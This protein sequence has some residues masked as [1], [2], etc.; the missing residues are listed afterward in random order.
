MKKNMKKIGRIAIISLF[1]VVLLDLIFKPNQESVEAEEI[2]K[3]VDPGSGTLKQ[4]VENAEPGTILKL[5]AGSY[6]GLASDSDKT[7][8]IKE[9]ITIEG[10]DGYPSKTIINVPIVVE[11]SEKVIISNFTTS[12]QVVEPNFVF[13]KTVGKVDLDINNVYIYGILRGDSNGRFPRTEA[14]ALNVTEGLLNASES[15]RS[16]INITNSSL[17]KPGTHYGIRV[18][19]SN[20]TLNLNKTTVDSRISV[21]F[22]N[23]ENNIFNLENNSSITAPSSSYQDNETIVIK[24]Q[25]NLEINIDNSTITG[26]PP[27]GNGPTKMFSFSD[28]GEK[29]TNVK[30]NVKNNSKLID[31]DKKNNL[32]NSSIIFNYRKDNSESDNN[33]ITIDNTSKVYILILEEKNIPEE[34]MEVPISREYS[35]LDNSA[36]VSIFDSKGNREI[37]IYDNETPIAELENINQKEGYV[38]KGWFKTFENNEYSN[39]YGKDGNYP[40]AKSGEN[41]DL[42]PKF[43][44]K[45][46]ITIGEE[47]FAI[48]E[49]QTINESSNSET[50]KEALNNIKIKDGQDFRGF[51]I[52]NSNGSLV[53]DVS[54][55]EELLNLKMTEDCKIEAT[56]QVKVTVNGQD[57]WI[58][59]GETLNDI[60]DR[61]VYEEAKNLNS[62]GRE[63]SRFV[64][65][66]GKTVTEEE[67][68]PS[69]VK[70]TSKYFQKVTIDGKDYN[71]EEGLILNSSEEIKNALTSI[72]KEIEGRTFAK[73][74][75]AESREEIKVNEY[76]VNKDITVKAIYTITV[77][78]KGKENPN[79]KFTIEADN[80][81]RSYGNDDEIIAA[82][83]DVEASTPKGLH[84]DGYVVST[85]KDSSNTK[86]DTEDDT[87]ENLQK[88]ILD[89]KLSN[90]TT[91]YA[92]YVVKITIDNGTSSDTFEIESGQTLND[93]LNDV[94]YKERYQAVKLNG[95]EEN[96][97]YKF[98][99]S[100]NNEI[101]ETDEITKSMTLTPKYLVFVTIEDERDKVKGKF[102]LEEGDS[103]D[104]LIGEDAQN[105]LAT[106]RSDIDS[107]EG[108]P[109]EDYHFDKLVLADNSEIP[110]KITEDITIKA[111]YHYDVII[112]EDYDNPTYDDVIEVHEGVKGFKVYKGENLLSKEDE[113]R[114]A[115]DKLKE[116]VNK[117]D[118]RKFYSYLEVNTN[119]EFTEAQFDELLNHV[120]KTHIYISAKVAYKV[121]INDVEDYVVEGKSLKDSE[122]GLLVAEL[123]KLKSQPDKEVNKIIINGREYSANEVD[124]N[125]II[126]EYTEIT[127]TYN[128]KVS[129]N[130]HEF[131]LPENGKLEDL[132]DKTEEIDNAL[133]ELKEQIKNNNHNFKEFID[134]DGNSFTKETVVRKNTTVIATY[135]IKVTIESAAGSKEFEI[136]AGQ[137]LE[138]VKQ[139]NETAFAEVQ[140][141]ENRK[142][143]HFIVD[144]S[145]KTI[146]NADDK[147]YKFTENTTLTSIYAVTVTINDKGYDIK[148]GSTLGTPEI[149]E[150]LKDFESEEK[151]L[152]G[153][154]YGEDN[155]AITIND[156]VNDNITIKPVYS[157]KLTIKY[158]EEVLGEFE[159]DENT[160]INDSNELKQAIKDALDALKTK[161]TTAGYNFKKFVANDEEFTENTK[162]TKN[163]IVN[164]NYN[165]MVTI[166]NGSLTKEFEL[167]SNQTLNDIPENK[168]TD[169]QEVITKNNRK[170]ADK[171]YDESKN[172]ITEKTSLVKNITL[173]PI[174]N[175]TVTIDGKGYDIE[176]GTTLG[177][178]EIVEALKVFE[179]TEKKLNGYVYGESKTPIKIT[180]TVNDNITISPV[181]VVI[182]TIKDGEVV[183]GE[184]EL[185]ENTS[186][187]ENPAKKQEIENALNTLKNQVISNG[188]NF[189]GYI[190][191]NGNTFTL[192]TKITKNIVVGAI[193]NIKVTIEGA[194]GSKEFEIEAGQTLED[195]KN[196]NQDDFAEVQ[197]KDNRKFLYFI[198][199]DSNNTKLNADDKTYK[200]AKNTS[201]T[202]V[203][204]VTVT[205][206][207]KGYDIK[208]GG[209][210]SSYPQVI[211]ALKKLEKT[212]QRLVEYLDGN[213]NIIATVEE[214]NNKTDKGINDNLTIKPKYVIDVEIVGDTTY[215]ETV[216]VGT[217]LSEIKYPKPE[218]FAGYVDYNTNAPVEETTALTKHTKL[219]VIYKVKVSINEN[220]YYLNSFQ[221]FGEL[222]GAEED[223]EAL[224]EVP[225][226]KSSFNKFIYI[227]ANNEEI[228]L[229]KDTII[230][231]DI[232][233]LPKFNVEITVVYKNSNDELE[234]II[235]FELEDGKAIGSLPKEELDKLNEKLNE[236]TSQLEE[237]GKLNYK[238]S[239]FITNEGQDIDIKATSFTLNTTIEAVFE[240]K[241]ESNPV[242]PEK[243]EDNTGSESYPEKEPAPNT[244]VFTTSSNNDETTKT[245]ITLLTLIGSILLSIKKIFLRRKA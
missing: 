69:N 10:V 196:T 236:K 7:I 193:H 146:L 132:T 210:L 24:E 85:D 116:S 29:S 161:V 47:E 242:T 33:V 190:D 93:I 90:D 124:E 68:I 215:K 104:N 233:V 235:K 228:T 95:R 176:E 180:D 195:V 181:Y 49:G 13:I 72:S 115:L 245:N 238:F 137:T 241:E 63:F 197:K 52:Y 144:D 122:K 198:V 15:E 225:E 16:T 149:I 98:V 35:V 175:V 34:I 237:E 20:T 162:I 73:F 165:I 158:G 77:T 8:T 50:I 136:D 87:I 232:T 66:E 226:G 151:Q 227:N 199:S 140:K 112:V 79:R 208:E 46:K 42:Y 26:N 58:E 220:I 82:L 243:P 159:L 230:S 18:A 184:F 30:I 178:P 205:I 106:L 216:E 206:D 213:G 21:I 101:K 123:N 187:N 44:K 102:N 23:G 155:K 127:A 171:F 4:A 84:F 89:K 204:A 170:F 167:E 234:D 224:K 154:V 71:I 126:N 120:F 192:D 131:I 81:L 229:N 37:K 22:E 221:T 56:H 109:A 11:T 150:A 209:K 99:D 125:T 31:E 218:S 142:F 39:E 113:A 129:I 211:E 80:N 207:G 1:M 43:A 152:K 48:E 57:F 97:F 6:N 36:V 96:R 163:T 114:A 191:N 217:L 239:K 74:V 86:F 51:I 135:N 169:Y 83:D 177:T 25:K 121:K 223:L 53:F 67:G 62:N 19:A 173:T 148:E 119:S 117:K 17:T 128:V 134:S 12:P 92:E 200:F 141:K 244:G 60:E 110:S 145:D 219:K 91:I 76:E 179:S 156:T 2:I 143:L 14:M 105:K 108:K 94:K 194:T 130:G 88:A 107:E 212:E 41:L 168:Q 75:D 103:I 78:F 157:V 55:E 139:A 214:V 111:L 188:Y 3:Y 153:Y 160:S 100:D 174:F 240:E 172:V 202:S 5:K 45:L 27:Y 65:E 38:F 70:L 54:K 201:L 118:T 32:S 164:A 147:T 64:N 61:T 9:G 28:E 133:N 138:H 182:L 40:P 203:Y 59:S 166:K 222:Q 185:D 231:S 186:A 183:L 189:K